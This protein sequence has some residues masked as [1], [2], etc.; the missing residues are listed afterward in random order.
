MFY[1]ILGTWLALQCSLVAGRLTSGLRSAAFIVSVGAILQAIVLFWLL[2]FYRFDFCKSYSA[3]VPITATVIAH[4]P[5]SCP[6]SNG[7]TAWRSD[8]I[9][10][11]CLVGCW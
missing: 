10:H 5:L 2:L 8:T 6:Q 3:V 4:S 9:I 1:L 7:W 11:R